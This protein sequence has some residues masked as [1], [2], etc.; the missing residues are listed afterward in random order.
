MLKKGSFTEQGLCFFTGKLKINQTIV[1]R[2]EPGKINMLKLDKPN[3]PACDLF[4]NGKWV[5]TLAWEP[6]D[7]DITEYVVDGENN[8]QLLLYAS[9]RN[10][11]GPHHYIEGESYSVDPSTFSDRGGWFEGH[12]NNIWEESYCFVKFGI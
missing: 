3:A 12:S 6:F 4:V 2:K 5:K 8:I 10:L 9:N 7:T 1:V 11:L